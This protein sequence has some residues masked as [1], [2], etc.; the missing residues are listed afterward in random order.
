VSLSLALALSAALWSARTASGDDWQPVSPDELKMTS[1][2]EAP[3][4]PAVLLYRQV[5]R[6]DGRIPHEETYKR[7][8]I[9]TEEG[10]KY[11]NVEI[12]FVKG[13]ENVRGV[14]ARTVKPD[15][16][17]VRFDG[18]VYE[19]TI[20]KAKGLK[21]LAKTITLP[22]VQVGGIIEY[23]YSVDYP[24]GWVYDSKWVLSDE[25]FTRR[26][27]FALQANDAFALRWSWPLG[28]PAGSPPPKEEGHGTIRMESVNIPAFQVEDYMPPENSL[29]YRVD[30]IYTEEGVPEKD[31]AKFWKSYAKK[32]YEGVENFANR[33]KAMEQAV[34]QTVTASDSPQAKL[35]KI[36]ARVQQ[37]RNTSIEKEKTEQEM[38]RDKEKEVSNVEDVW[39]RGYGNGAQITWLFLGMARA[40]GLEASPVMVARRN[41]NFFNSN[42]MNENQLNDNVVLVRLDG[43][44]LFFDPGTAFTPY[45][46]LPW[47]ETTVQGM[48][49]A[50]DGGSWVDIPAADSSRTVIERKADLKL[51]TEG[52]LTGKLTVSYSGA[53]AQALR[54]DEHLEDDTSRK[55]MLEDMVRES[56][57]AAIEVELS[58]KPDWASSSATLVAEF[59]LKVPGWVSGA[60]KRAMFP[61]GLF[62]SAEKGVFDHG[63]R[64]YPVYIH[65]PYRKLDDIT[66]EM[67]LGWKVSSVAKPLDTDVKAAAYTLKS[68][69]HSGTLHLSRML[70]CDLML[71][72]KENYGALR[73]FFQLVR[74]GDDEQVVLAPG[75]SSAGN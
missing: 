54:L 17:I 27:K 41:Q 28:L 69:E 37:I 13:V 39:K 20:V 59:T 52:T 47:W 55:K 62:S 45:G 4:A 51:D 60:G 18:K 49:L 32:R 8:K 14:K 9:L 42:V 34:A 74:T 26:A 1:V 33:K 19:Q 71:V 56:I 38:K 72:P 5:D 24:S 6:D 3:G 57:P 67:P 46:S 68:E 48:K 64:L 23:K 10:R 30:F 43:R 44:D 11:A 50:K 22:D 61:V 31:P 21:F 58:N 15:G 40:A 35:E 70:R 75:S 7:I 16:T 63:T 65:Y 73:N 25:L 29:K 53:E 66:V 2:P 12:P 36:Y